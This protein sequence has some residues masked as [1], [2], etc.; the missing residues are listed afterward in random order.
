M[1]AKKR[2]VAAKKITVK[3]QT[4]RKTSTSTQ[5]S[6]AKPYGIRRKKPGTGGSGHFYRVEIR[7]KGVFNTF[8]TQDVGEKGGLERIAGKRSSGSWDTVTWLISK[9]KSHISK[10]GELII[11]DKK[12]RSMLSQISGD[13]THVQGDVFH[14]HPRKNISE[15]AKPTKAMKIARSKNI[16]KAQKANQNK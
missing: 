14:A 1:K 9:D 3:T 12:A 5:R 6:L 8:R 4:K 15:K 11:D 10:T 7:P 16:K 13:I 2:T